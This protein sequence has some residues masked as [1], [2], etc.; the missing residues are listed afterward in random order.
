MRNHARA[1][2]HKNSETEEL[3]KV[4]CF[5]TCDWGGKGRP[6]LRALTLCCKSHRFITV[7]YKIISLNF[8]VSHGF[9]FFLFFLISPSKD[10]SNFLNHTLMSHTRTKFFYTL[11]EL[12]GAVATY[13][14]NFDSGKFQKLWLTY[15]A[16]KRERQHKENCMS[17]TKLDCRKWL[18][19][20][21]FEIYQRKITSLYFK[22]DIKCEF[23]APF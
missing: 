12:F 1:E 9:C 17:S 19:C 4:E 10:F 2:N 13:R 18:N 23:L 11:K 14:L 6:Q 16:N 21:I 22:P 20:I 5:P 3:S 7:Y 15:W 8:L